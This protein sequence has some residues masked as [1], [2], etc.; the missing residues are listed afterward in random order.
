MIEQ[1][2]EEE[3]KTAKFAKAFA[4]PARVRILKFLAEQNNC[5]CGNIVD[6]IPLSQSTVSQ[7]LKELKEAGL[8]HGR[9]EPPKVYYCIDKENWEYAKSLFNNLM[10]SDIINECEIKEIK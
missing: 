6:Y 4:H 2:N 5:F 8:I 1:F 9:Y 3:I 10:N 7:H